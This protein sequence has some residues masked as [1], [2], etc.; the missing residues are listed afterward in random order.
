MPWR[1]RICFPKGGTMV[2][3]RCYHSEICDK[4]SLG[5]KR[6]AMERKKIEW[7]PDQVMGI[8]KG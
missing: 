3:G 1:V 4:I 2:T 8:H 6:F 7:F 5:C